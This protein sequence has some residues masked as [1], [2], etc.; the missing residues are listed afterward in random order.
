MK[1]SELKNFVPQEWIKHHPEAR[2]VP[3]K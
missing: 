1:Q 3:V 2:L